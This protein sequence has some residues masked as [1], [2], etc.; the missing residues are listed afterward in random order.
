MLADKVTGNLVGLWLLVPELMRLGAWDLLCGWTHRSP[1]SVEPRLALQLVH[2]AALCV[3]GVRA[4]RCL[5]QRGFELVNGLPFLAAD[6][7]VHELL[8]ART[9]ADC[10]DLQVALGKIRRASGHYQGRIL[11]IDPHRV[12]S[13]SRRHMSQHRGQEG[14]RPTKVAQTF[15]VL[16]ADTHQPVCF[17][18][19][20]SARTA[21]VAAMELL[22]LAAA[23]LDPRPG[24]AL[25]LV[26]TE[27]FTA[28][29]LD[30]VQC[31]TNLDLLVPMPNQRASLAQ[32][33][34]LAPEQFQ[35]RWAG[36]ATCK[37]LYTPKNSAAGPF[38][39]FIQRTGE[40]PEDYHFKAFLSTR[41][42]DEAEALTWEF[43]K[44]WHV[45]EFFNA[46]QALGWDRAGT[47]NLHI[48]Y[49]TVARKPGDEIMPLW[50]CAGP[51]SCWSGLGS[52][53]LAAGPVPADPRSPAV[54]VPGR[55]SSA[56]FGYRRL[57]RS[58]ALDV[59][60][61]NRSSRNTSA[62]SSPR[63]SS[64][65]STA[66][67]PADRA[68]SVQCRQLGQRR[69]HPAPPVEQPV[70]LLHQLAQPAELWTPAGDPPQ[71]RPLGGTEMPLDEQIAVL[72]QLADLALDRL[73]AAG[74]TPGGLVGT[75]PA[76][77]QLRCRGGQPLA[78]LCHGREDRL[79][80][81]AKDMEGAD[82]MRDLAED[83]GDRL[84]IQRRAVGRNP[85][86]GQPAGIEGLMEAAEERRDV[87]VGRVV[88][89]DLVGQPL[90]GAVVDDREDA[91]RPV[92]QLV[93][94][95]IAR[96]VGEGPV[97]MLG[98]DPS[99][100]LFPPASTQFWIVA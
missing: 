61:I 92:I 30:H 19:A 1:L 72:K 67:S 24:Q 7:A 39:Q 52:D 2:E 96:E 57:P 22:R 36:Y 69:G 4:R 83:L 63:D 34:S 58:T 48:R 64:F 73:L 51:W 100:R 10:Q 49:D 81:F 17:T 78:L 56:S 59:A 28:Q 70:D 3:T 46:N 11:A 26:D 5:N 75:R 87:L 33:G 25:V 54:S 6:T 53:S 94:G 99:R 80:Q 85:T 90:E 37:R 91:E 31:E 97:E 47:C 9:V 76:P 65:F 42:G 82:L 55:P 32:L 38:H 35:P 86:D 41:D 88:V 93:Y 98:I 45:E 50:P 18:T 23:V 12:R 16:D 15:F 44:R 77:R 40:R 68:S 27:H 14:E 79:G 8:G 29:L 20:T 21:T 74:R 89:E 71:R 60:P 13:Y 62:F 84:G 66:R 95:E 43:P